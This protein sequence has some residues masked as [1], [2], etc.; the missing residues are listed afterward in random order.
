MFGKDGW[1]PSEVIVK[2][3]LHIFNVGLILFYLIVGIR[4][5]LQ[6]IVCLKLTVVAPP[7]GK[8]VWT[9]AGWSLCLHSQS[10]VA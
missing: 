8:K 4:A 9:A 1:K 10:C 3:Q 6:L 7:F 2:Y 5:A